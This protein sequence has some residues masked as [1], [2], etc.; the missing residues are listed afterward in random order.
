MNKH[1]DKNMISE[2]FSFKS[3]YS[4]FWLALFFVQATAFAWASPKEVIIFPDSA[5]VHEQVIAPVIKQ[6]KRILME[7]ILPPQADPETMNISFRQPLT[8]TDITWE[9]TD[10]L[11]I[12]QVIILREK[13]DEL[14]RKRTSL[15]IS[16]RSAEKGASFWENQAGFQ[17]DEIALMP[18]ISRSI[19]SN[20]QD[21]YTRVQEMSQ[22]LE[23]TDKDI[24][25]LQRRIEQI[26]GPEKKVW[27][28]RVFVEAHEDKQEVS[29]AYNYILKNCGWRSFY[30]LEANP[31][32]DHIGFTWQA[33]VWQSS[34][35]DWDDVE[36][37]LA[38]LEPQRELV[39]RPIPDWIVSPR[40]DFL[41][42][43]RMAEP[44]KE[45]EMMD[46][47]S[48][49]SE[50]VP[51]LERTG[52]FSQWRLG[53]R[54]LAAGDKPR[55]NIQEEIWPAEFTHLVRPSIND[56]AFIRAEIEFEQARDLPR[57]EAMF[58]LDGAMVGKRFLRIAGN[59]ETMFFGHDPFVRA[60]LITREKKSGA[61]GIFA[62]RQTYLWDFIIRLENNQLYPVKI[63][64]EEPK[65]LLR[66]ER[67]KA[68]FDFNP[69][70]DDQHENLFI[71][72]LT[73]E[74][75]SNAEVRLNINMEAPKDMEVDW[76]WRR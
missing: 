73:M 27:K 45:L 29:I 62:N 16:I 74:P 14:V 67:I 1:Q 49:G 76:G 75:G 70:P 5:L 59:E 19:T 53:K 50:A 6:D 25:D 68:S 44:A 63:R 69:D 20:L 57:G 9:R 66:D 2:I 12:S 56:R 54:S 3:L 11:E 35:L 31:G 15:E 41:P 65:P 18:E 36:M 24:K 52:T 58:L 71:W 55:F 72:N 17:I 22:E 43:A 21:I 37:S 23:Q 46:A 4:S 61:R 38:T 32:E 26:T 28:V 10:P 64:L 33:E 8:V 47:R 39:P 42:A 60:E 30:R 51:V 13:L 48:A 7:L 40:S 34:G